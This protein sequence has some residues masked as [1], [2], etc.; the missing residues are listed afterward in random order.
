MA[1]FS[2]SHLRTL[3]VGGLALGLALRYQAARYQ[4]W[5]LAG[6]GSVCSAAGLYLF[7]HV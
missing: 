2:V 6:L 5:T 4:H 1:F 7:S 3:L